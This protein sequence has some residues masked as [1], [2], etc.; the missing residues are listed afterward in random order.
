[1]NMNASRTMRA[2]LMPAQ[3]PHPSP[4]DTQMNCTTAHYHAKRVRILGQRTCSTV[5][6]Q[7][8][9]RISNHLGAKAGNEEEKHR[10]LNS[11]N[12]FCKFSFMF[13][14]LS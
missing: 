4:S 3:Q 13:Y 2:V 5:G 6:V 8:V 11:A 14:S 1:M 7:A 12:S 10:C 9:M